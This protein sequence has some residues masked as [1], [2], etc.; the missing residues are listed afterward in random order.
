MSL[1]SL[2]SASRLVSRSGW[3]IAA[4]LALTGML[5]ACSMVRLAYNNADTA[6]RVMAQDY[7]DLWSEDSTGLRVQIARLHDWHRRE[8]LPVY[9]DLLQA[10]A[11]KLAAGLTRADIEWAAAKGRERYRALVVRAADEAAPLLAKLGPDHHAA[12]AKKM[13]NNNAKFAREFLGDDPLERERARI[14]R[15]V[16]YVED[17]TG[18][19]TSA[20]EA[21]I[22][23]TVRAFPRLSELQLASRQ[24]RQ[25]VLLA[26]LKRNRSVAELAPAL[27]A[28]FL[29]WELRRGSEY[30]RMATD[31]EAQLTL[32]LLD[33]DRTLTP[34]QRSRAVERAARFAEDFRVLADPKA[35]LAEREKL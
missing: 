22:A 18:S 15:L 9:A 13:A 10:G 1:M 25:Q 35:Q 24:A 3:R 12:L 7:F 32:L 29:D 27:R 11:D 21:R 31:W 2:V 33:L 8:E 19:L 6:V 5:A 26:L 14:K 34:E 16:G 28:Y 20:Q 23:T 30:G 17:W 4:L